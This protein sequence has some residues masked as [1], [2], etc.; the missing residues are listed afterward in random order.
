ME[1]ILRAV[2]VYFVVWL[3]FRIAGKRT[4]SQMTMFD[5]VLLLIIAEGP[6][7]PSSARTIPSP[8]RCWRWRPSW[9]W[10]S[11]SRS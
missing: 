5:F 1:I 3:F 11:A 6:S 2:T 10:T 8:A 9:A 7:R 4:L